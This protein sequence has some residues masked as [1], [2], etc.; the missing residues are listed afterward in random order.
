[1]LAAIAEI[2]GPI[3]TVVIRDVPEPGELC[4]GEV[5]VRMLVSTFNPSDAVTVSGAYASRTTFPLVPGFEGVGIIDRIGPGVPT[6]ALGRRVLPI[7]SPGAWQGYKRTDH[8]WCIPVPDDI[9]TDVACFAYINPL[10]A[11]L[12]VERFCHGVQSALV[13]AA[14][15]T[16][17]GHLKALLEQ[18]GIETVTVERTWGTVGVDKQF[19]VAFDCVGGEVGRRVA[20]AVKPDG[21]MVCCRVSRWG[22]LGGGLRCFGCAMW[23]MRVRVR[24][25]R[26]YLRTCLRSYGRVGCVVGWRGRFIWGMCR[27]RCG[28]ISRGRENC[29]LGLGIKGGYSLQ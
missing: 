18:R 28:S 23:C 15:T 26:S 22:R 10:T 14:T 7:G 21:T 3:D 13:D 4:A 6:S 12:M 17:A 29:S 24:S 9:L 2:P 1:M 11:S 20:R 8:S 5:V 25:C 16:I 19:D 27:R